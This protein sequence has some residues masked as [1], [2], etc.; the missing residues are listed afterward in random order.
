MRLRFTFYETEHLSCCCIHR[1]SCVANIVFICKWVIREEWLH[2]VM[3]KN[4]S[5]QKGLC[6]CEWFHDSCGK[7]IKN[8]KTTIC[9]HSVHLVKK[10]AYPSGFVFEHTLKTQ[11]YKPEAPGGLQETH[12]H[13]VKTFLPYLEIL[14]FESESFWT[15][16]WVFYLCLS[17]PLG[18]LLRFKA[19]EKLK[20][21]STTIQLQNLNSKLERRF[22]VFTLLLRHCYSSD[23][24]VMCSTF[25][26]YYIR[27]S[28]KKNT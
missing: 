26:Y 20:L 7:K 11:N 27:L 2:S 28:D 13:L 4:A 9:L 18:C 10:T 3:I 16:T 17:A 6:T 22:C 14:L 8:K 1:L 19:V 5:G 21:G 23:P 24:Y 15:G 25:F 12:I